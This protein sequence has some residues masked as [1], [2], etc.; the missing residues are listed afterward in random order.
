MEWWKL[1]LTGFDIFQYFKCQKRLMTILF[2]YLF[3]FFFWNIERPYANLSIYWSSV[4]ENYGFRRVQA[5]LALFSGL[6][7]N[8][9]LFNDL[10]VYFMNPVTLILMMQIFVRKM[11][12]V[13]LKFVKSKT[14][15]LFTQVLALIH[16]CTHFTGL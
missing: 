13:D 8:K 4:E 16:S 10:E 3:I 14:L 5:F 15:A 2:F 7:A 11:R 6:L 1:L 12:N 9:H